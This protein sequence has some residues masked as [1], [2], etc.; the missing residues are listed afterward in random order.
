MHVYLTSSTL[1]IALQ[2]VWPVMVVITGIPGFMWLSSTL[3]FTLFPRWC[4]KIG[5][6]PEWE[7]SRRTGMVRVWRYR[8]SISTLW[9]SRAT[10]IE[11]PF[12][13]FDGWVAGITRPGLAMRFGIFSKII[14][15]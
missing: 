1:L 5:R 7:L 9:R 6:G 3:A 15:M 12:Y 4:V 2:E 13:E 10:I 14:W 11:A 8:R